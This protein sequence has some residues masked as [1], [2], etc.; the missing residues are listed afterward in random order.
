M[1]KTLIVGFVLF[2]VAMI[3][4]SNMTM[5]VYEDEYVLI[6]RFGKIERIVDEA[7]LALKVP[8]LEQS[9]S[10][11]KNIQMY[12]Q[13]ESD[14][15]TKD[16]KTMTVDNYVVWEISDPLKFVQKIG[17]I[18]EAERRISNSIYNAIKIHIGR[19]T[20]DEVVANRNGTLEDDILL[21]VQDS[22]EEYGI[23]IIRNEIKGLDLPNENKEAVYNRMISERTQIAEK[24]R[25][26]G[27]EEGQKIRNETDKETDIIK[28]TATA[29]AEQIRAEGEAEYMRIIAEAY[30]TPERVEFYEFT[31][32]LDAL[33]ETMKGNNK[34]LFLPIDSPLTE[35]FLGK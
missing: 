17:R 9:E 3:L 32:S 15:I 29:Q 28:S 20:Q 10:L 19:M 13:A 6:K 11:P 35:I 22:F 4:I 1:K 12:D 16:K 21:S 18:S 8:I 5:Y 2:L 14:V 26:E 24:Y 25:A 31:R 27:K 7:G 23:R 34:T 30:N 33:K